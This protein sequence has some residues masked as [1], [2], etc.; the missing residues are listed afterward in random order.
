MPT[1]IRRA[2]LRVKQLTAASD[3]ERLPAALACSGFGSLGNIRSNLVYHYLSLRAGVWANKAR[4]S[5]RWYLENG[6]QPALRGR[7]VRPMSR[8]GL[9]QRSLPACRSAA[10]FLLVAVAQPH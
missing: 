4:H 3:R 5:R 8:A 2:A 10:L 6:R 9:A 1:A 7:P